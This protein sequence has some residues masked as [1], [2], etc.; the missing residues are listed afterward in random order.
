MKFNLKTNLGFDLVNKMLF[1]LS[2]HAMS[3]VLGSAF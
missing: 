1:E 2:M 3:S